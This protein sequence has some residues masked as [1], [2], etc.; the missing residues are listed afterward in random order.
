MERKVERKSKKKENEGKVKKMM[1]NINRKR[2]RRIVSKEDLKKKRR[3]R[4]RKKKVFEKNIEMNVEIFIG[5]RK[6]I[7]KDVDR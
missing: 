6:D 3:N 4:W 1:W 2:F 7:M 5:K